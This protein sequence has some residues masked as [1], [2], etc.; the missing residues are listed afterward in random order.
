M[1]CVFAARSDTFQWFALIGTTS[2]LL[3]PLITLWVGKN[4]P[5]SLNVIVEET[6]NC[7][8]APYPVSYALTTGLALIG[9]NFSK[10][11]SYPKDETII[12]IGYRSFERDFPSG[13]RF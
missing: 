3:P 7:V 13:S 6:K 5:F 1:L 4:T 12:T 10:I 2:T 9:G 8:F 11:L